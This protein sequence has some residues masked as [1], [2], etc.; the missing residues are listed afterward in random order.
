MRILT[1]AETVPAYKT[2]R[3]LKG[4]K[5]DRCGKMLEP[6]RSAAVTRSYGKDFPRY[7]EVTTGHNDWGNDSIESFKTEDIC[8]DCLPA[9]FNEWRENNSY[10]AQFEV[11]TEGVFPDEETTYT[12]KAPTQGSTVEKHRDFW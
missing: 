7:Y 9:Y 12:D 11:K 2:T 3:K 10:T 5:C 6:I 4:V 8:E 1:N